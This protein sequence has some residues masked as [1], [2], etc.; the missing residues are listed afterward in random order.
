MISPHC[1]CVGNMSVSVYSKSSP[2]SCLVMPA[3]RGL[4]LFSKGQD[5]LW[6]HQLCCVCLCTCKNVCK[7]SYVCGAL[8]LLVAIYKW[9]VVCVSLCVSTYV[10][11]PHKWPTLNEF[12]QV[13]FALCRA[14]L[15]YIPM[16]PTLLQ[17]SP[18]ESSHNIT[19]SPF[20]WELPRAK[21]IRWLTTSLKIWRE[22]MRHLNLAWTPHSLGGK[23][24]REREKTLESGR[25]NSVV[26]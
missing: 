13:G 11:Q 25:L 19:S 12:L 1:V 4:Q 20:D 7:C 2:P 6:R 17:S 15:D 14:V 5:S 8:M 21:L 3:K 9:F 24:E 18:L 26:S 16:I 23:K 22:T 10:W